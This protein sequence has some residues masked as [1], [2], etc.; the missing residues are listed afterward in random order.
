VIDHSGPATY[1]THLDRLAV[2]VDDPVRGGQPLG[3]IGA[4]PSQGPRAFKH[5]HFE[6]WPDGTRASAIDPQPRM[7]AWSRIAFGAPGAP[8]TIVH[9]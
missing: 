4:D 3:I 5:L 9:P 2:A 1:Y 8:V 6:L 7:R